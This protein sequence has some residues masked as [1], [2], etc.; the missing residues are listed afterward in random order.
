MK[1]TIKIALGVIMAFVI[2]YAIIILMAFLNFKEKKS[3]N[4]F[5]DADLSS[6]NTIE[7]IN[8]DEILFL[9][10]GVDDSGSET[11][12]RTDTLMLIKANKRL[13]TVDIISI[14]R[15]T[16]CYVDGRLDKI[17]AAHS[18]GGIENTIKS[19]RN[20]LGIDVDYYAEINFDGVMGVVDSIGGVN[21][22]VSERVA[23]AMGMNP[24][25]H[26]FN[27]KEALNFVRFR[28]GYD[29][30]D[31]GR[32]STQQEFLRQ[33]SSQV[34]RPT[35]ILKWPIILHTIS[36]SVDTNIPK[37]TA[38]K[39]QRALKNVKPENIHSYVIPGEAENIEDIS[40]YVAYPE[41]TIQLRD[42]VL[43][44]YIIK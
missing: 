26:K 25:M 5:T 2:I 37:M 9:L 36:K 31:L 15:D 32:I 28:K 16:R 13:K 17:N 19:I 44:D 3:S 40:Y 6:T 21:I 34:M 22:D 24:G 27:G 43:S 10:A 39:F 29:N 33:M 11:G 8:K 23:Y 14:P 1:K 35:N 20:F 18:Y 4:N 42:R 38:L 12:T 7:Q 41:E 30:Q